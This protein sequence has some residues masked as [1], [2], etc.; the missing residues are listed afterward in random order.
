MNL[1]F[2]Q[3]PY[4]NPY[5]NEQVNTFNQQLN[6]IINPSIQPQQY[7]LVCGNKTDWDEFLQLN[8]GLSEKE[9]FDDYKIFLQAKAEQSQQESQNK[10]QRFK[11]QLGGHNIKPSGERVCESSN[12]QS[13][14]MSKTMPS[15][16]TS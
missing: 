8:Y 14:Q 6:G 12:G 2:Y 11:E 7:V 9:I 1:N 4:A 3:N 10:L 16:K 13:K 5:T 15:E